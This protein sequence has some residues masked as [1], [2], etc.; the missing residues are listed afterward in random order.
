[1]WILDPAFPLIG[2]LWAKLNKMNWPVLTRGTCCTLFEINVRPNFKLSKQ[3][4]TPSQ[5]IGLYADERDDLGV[6]VIL[7]K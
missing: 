7:L 1:M 5:T 2:W 4:V 3:L 6:S